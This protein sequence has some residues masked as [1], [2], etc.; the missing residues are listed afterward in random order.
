M[1]GPNERKIIVFK[2]LFYTVENDVFIYFC[3]KLVYDVCM[4]MSMRMNKTF[5]CKKVVENQK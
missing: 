4:S 5:N 2:L 1:N 3:F